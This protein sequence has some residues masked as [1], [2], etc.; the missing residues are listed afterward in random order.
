MTSQKSDKTRY[1]EQIKDYILEISEHNEG[2]RAK[3]LYESRYVSDDDLFSPENLAH[4][5]IKFLAGYFH[6]WE[7]SVV[8]PE[9]IVK[10]LIDNR[11]D[12]ESIFQNALR[13]NFYD[14]FRF[15]ICWKHFFYLYLL[16]NRQLFHL[17]NAEQ[18]KEAC[19]TYRDFLSSATDSLNR[20]VGDISGI[21]SEGVVSYKCAL[22]SLKYLSILDDKL[23]TVSES[24]FAIT[25]FGFHRTLMGIGEDARNLFDML[26]CMGYRVELVDC[27]Y[28]G[29]ERDPNADFYT[30]FETT[31]PSA[32]VAIFCMPLFEMARLMPKLSLQFFKTRYT[33]GYWP[34]ELTSFQSGWRHIGNLV[35]EI[36]ASSEFLVNIYQKEFDKPIY[37]MPLY[38]RVSEETGSLNHNAAEQKSSS[39]FISVFDFNSSISRKNPLA[40]VRSF[41]KAFPNSSDNNQLIFKTINGS[42][43][44]TFQK[45]LKDEIDN[46]P[47][48][49]IIDRP[50]LKSELN[51]LISSADAFISLHRS[52][53]FG[54]LLCEAMLL[55]VPVIAT[56]WSG[57]CDFVKKEHAFPIRYQLAK[58]GTGQYPY[59]AGYWADVEIEHA[60][61]VLRVIA[62]G[63]L[64]R[65]L[66]IEKAANFV[67]EK[68]GFATVS[69]KLA[70]RL[71]S[72]SGASQRTSFDQQT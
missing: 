67:S 69:R 4:F 30:M 71:K 49:V 18:K 10:F 12:G 32:E 44:P 47:R 11:V 38:V 68:F 43:N 36:W 25:L 24:K 72:I 61:Q 63:S 5:I 45:I 46:D 56:D 50:M 54:R 57:S 6:G 26:T 55:K 21:Y 37:Y 16:P 7:A 31:S 66:L 14:K 59:A 39:V 3:Y 34:W 64:D 8:L 40:A 48:I 58:V 22:N 9:A 17:T 20:N 65:K 15:E 41:K 27:T 70:E 35:N 62:Y 42:R 19:L 52:E 2:F 51:L 60:A 1:A 29:M 33:I 13:A 23:R 28:E 53:G